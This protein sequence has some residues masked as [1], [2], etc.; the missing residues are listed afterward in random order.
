MKKTVNISHAS[1]MLRLEFEVNYSPATPDYFC[2][3]H[4]NWL[5]GDRTEME[6]LGLSIEGVSVDTQ[7]LLFKT[8]SETF[9]NEILEEIESD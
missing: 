6:V 4:G 2:N 5:P 9:F 3:G 8:M 7:S 1:S